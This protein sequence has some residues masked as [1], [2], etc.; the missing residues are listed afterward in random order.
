MSL[1]DKGSEVLRWS[2]GPLRLLWKLWIFST[3]SWCPTLWSPMTPGLNR[4]PGSR[5]DSWGLED[6]GDR[7]GNPLREEPRFK[8]LRV[9]ASWPTP[10]HLRSEGCLHVITKPHD[11]VWSSVMREV[12]KNKLQLGSPQAALPIQRFPWFPCSGAQCSLQHYLQ[13]PGHGSNLD[14]HQQMNA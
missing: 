8:T 3:S 6:R 4:Q 11:N 13:Q 2:P 1:R 5:F 7:A 14:V 10:C 9:R 12:F